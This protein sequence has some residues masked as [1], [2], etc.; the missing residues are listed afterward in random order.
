M[1]ELLNDMIDEI[2]VSPATQ[3]LKTETEPVVLTKPLQSTTT[4]SR[5]SSMGAI[6]ASS[7]PL[8]YNIKWIEFPNDESRKK[9]PI[10]MQNENGP[11]PLISICNVLFLRDDIK[12]PVDT[13]IVSNSK[14]LEILADS[15]FNH[16]LPL[17]SQQTSGFSNVEIILND[18]LG[19]MA[20]LQHGLDVNVKFSSC[21]SFEYTPELDIFDMYMIDLYHGWIIDPEQ[22]DFHAIL[23]D[24]SYNQIM[25]LIIA[26]DPD[27][28]TEKL[29]AENFL[30]I[31]ASQM[32]YYGL[33]ALHS[34]LKPGH[35][36]ILF[37]NNHF[38][39]IYKSPADNQLYIL[40]TD[41]G[42][43]NHD[44]IIWESLEN[45]DNDGRFF[46]SR[47]VEI[48]SSSAGNSPAKVSN[49]LDDKADITSE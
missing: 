31:S 15:L 13:E 20:K 8:F 23:A 33:A 44:Q 2:D 4:T 18:T 19:V 45:I 7:A 25:E 46:N 6:A 10:I 16:F 43:L 12:L 14:L 41:S 21:S 36:A 24:K 5:P 22:K 38:S 17:K 49:N 35:L 26:N 30:E 28:I 40:V 9:R 27:K 3:T 11:C 29:L 48:T 34:I 42:F 32:T 1:R 47:F 37:R 39:T